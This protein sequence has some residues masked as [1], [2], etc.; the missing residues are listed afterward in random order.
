MSIV[1]ATTQLIKARIGVALKLSAIDDQENEMIEAVKSKYL[2]KRAELKAN[3]DEAENALKALGYNDARIKELSL[4]YC[5]EN[6]IHAP[7]CDVEA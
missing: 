3:L 1:R 4:E 2:T 7:K 5:R 6:A